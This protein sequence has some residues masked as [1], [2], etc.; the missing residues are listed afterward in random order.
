MRNNYD[1]ITP[2]AGSA[3]MGAAGALSRRPPPFAS[4]DGALRAAWL[5]ADRSPVCSIHGAGNNASHPNPFDAAG[6][7]ELGRAFHCSGPRQV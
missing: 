5:I 3:P 2:H 6:A 7:W 4:G 1:A